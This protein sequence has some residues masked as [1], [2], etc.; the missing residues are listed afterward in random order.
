MDTYKLHKK[1][2]LCEQ[3]LLTKTW[4]IKKSGLSLLISFFSFLF[5]FK[6]LYILQY[7]SWGGTQLDPNSSKATWE[8]LLRFLEPNNFAHIP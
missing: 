3:V 5:F 8:P 4:I 1:R 2:G 6:L 7:C